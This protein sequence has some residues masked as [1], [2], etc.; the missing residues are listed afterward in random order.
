MKR[1]DNRTNILFRY[2]LIVAAILALSTRIV[3]KLVD[4]TVFSAEAWN[5]K[6]GEDLRQLYKVTPERGNILASDGSILAANLRFYTARIDFRSEKFNSRLYLDTIDAIC[7]SLAAKFPRRTARQWKSYLLEP[8]TKEKS[9]R[10]RAFPVMTN[11]NYAQLQWFK[12]LPFFNIKN[13]NRNG[14]VIEDYLRRVNP[15]GNMARRSIGGVG[16]TRESS[17]VHGISGLE[18]ALHS[19]LDGVP[20]EARKV[21]M[22][23][24]M[25]RW[26]EVPPVPGYDIL[27]TIDINLQDVVENELNQR[28]EFCDADWGVAVLMDVATGDI[29]A[30]SNLEKNAH[31]NGYIEGMNRAVLGYEPGSV[32]KTISMMVALED[33]IVGNPSEVIPTGRSW[34]YAGGRAITDAH[35]VDAVTVAEVIERSSN[36]GMAKIITRKYDNNPGGFYARLKQ[37]GFL[38]PMHTGIAGELPPRIDSVPNDRAGR[39]ALSRMCYGY[40]TEI[41][42]LYTLSIYNAIANGGRYVR[43]RLVERLI[44]PQTDSVLPVT[45]V[46]DR[47][48]SEKNAELLRKML[49]SVVW[50]DH[51][52]ARRLRSDLVSIAGKTGTCYMIENGSYNTSKKRLAF[53]GFFPADNPQY[54]CIVLTANPRQNAF[55]AA[56]TSGEVVK[57]I[58]LKLYSRGLLGNSSDYREGMGQTRVNGGEKV[59]TYHA[60]AINPDRAKALHA[61]LAIGG[62]HRSY[63]APRVTAPA[64]TVPAVSGLSAREA[65]SILEN[66]G[67]NVAINGSGSVRSQRP[68]PGTHAARGTRVTLTLSN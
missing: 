42:P 19:L 23:R 56:S 25:V 37:M 54:S 17:E 7:D 58:A 13:P 18:Q 14:L 43:P 55:G 2:G 50:G 15:Y 51:G 44:G 4:T 63:R 10:P 53:C 24:D 29:K 9:K 11:M 41:P 61:A 52:T 22:T 31:G 66:A 16:E 60:S 45:Y 47:V 49:T 57:G 6:A 26:T 39:I 32:V 28:L 5:A 64:G 21:A 20:G 34:A 38:E 12:T 35:G 48:C 40:A 8:M 65:V 27:T 46:R 62:G 3:G 33:G 1:G 59:P 30:I 68:S 36:I 67:Y